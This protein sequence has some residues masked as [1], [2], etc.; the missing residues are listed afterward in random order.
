MGRH[1]KA[2]CQYQENKL[3]WKVYQQQMF[4]RGLFQGRNFVVAIQV[5]SSF[6]VI[7]AVAMSLSLSP[8]SSVLLY[9]RKNC[10]AKAKSC[11]RLTNFV[12]KAR[13]A[14]LPAQNMPSVKLTEEGIDSTM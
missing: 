2:F 9:S 1:E 6:D 12:E 10:M 7:S 13:D 8:A 3:T 11:C 5:S 14:F 4:L